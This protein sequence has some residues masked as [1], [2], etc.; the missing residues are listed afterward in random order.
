MPDVLISCPKCGKGLKL[1]DRSKLGRPGRC[2]ACQHKFILQEPEEVELE[3]ADA[4]PA[5]GTG[6][7]WVPDEESAQHVPDSSRSPSPPFGPDSLP[8]FEGGS[9]LPLVAG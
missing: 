7:R 6:A 1:R 2:P 3:L 9:S 8:P 4:V 5:V